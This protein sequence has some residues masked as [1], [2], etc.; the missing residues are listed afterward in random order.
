M[1]ASNAVAATSGK[2]KSP[3][4]LILA[5]VLFT[6]FCYL[7]I[8]IP[9]AVIPSYVRDRLGFSPMLAGAAISSQ[10]IITVFTRPLAGRMSDTIGVKRNKF[11]YMDALLCARS[12][13]A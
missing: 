13:S 4:V 3:T 12:F 10:Y 11:V 5:V 6:G 8:G 2:T 7:S 1:D 9:L